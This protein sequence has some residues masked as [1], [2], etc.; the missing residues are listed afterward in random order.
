MKLKIFLT[1]ILAFTISIFVNAQNETQYTAKQLKVVTKIDGMEYI[2]EVISDD[3][4]EILLNTESLGKIYIPKSEIK[5]IVDVDNENRIVFGEFRTQGP[6]TTRYAFTNNAFPVEKGENYALINLYGPEVHF[7]ITNEF[8]LGIMST[9]IASPMVLAL[10]Y[11]FTTKNEN[12]NF[13]L[14][15][16]IGTSGYLNSFRGYGGL[17]WANVTFIE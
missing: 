9:W 11:S 8:S 14:G 7:A 17:H 6:F 2:G 4:R 13:S 1:L 12:I 15:T 3:G 16:L 5:S 10:K